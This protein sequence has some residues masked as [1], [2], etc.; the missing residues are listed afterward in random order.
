MKKKILFYKL[1][2]TKSNQTS[3][4]DDDVNTATDALKFFLDNNP[5]TRPYIDRHNK[6]IFNINTID[7]NHI[8][9]S[10]GRTEDVATNKFSRGR[11]RSSFNET[12]IEDLV[13]NYT[14][15]YFNSSTEK[16]AL[17]YNYKC[18]GFEKNFE[19]FL[20]TRIGLGESFIKISL[21]S[22]V[23]DEYTSFLST[24]RPI[25]EIKVAYTP[26]ND[27]KNEYL[28]LGETFSLS[29]DDIHTATVKL[30]L[31]TSADSQSISNDLLKNDDIAN[32]FDMFEITTE[33]ALVDAV[34]NTVTKKAT[35]YLTD[36]DYDD[37]DLIKEK[38]RQ[39]V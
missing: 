33:D 37:P 15:F 2:L 17:I 9:G 21:T 39:L 3:L 10:F 24:I 20:S 5:N 23:E 1:N 29:N 27:Y 26:E 7:E 6:V 4:L 28:T 30:K 34:T 8:F 31:K 11:E 12:T 35:I 22:V 16:V 14:Y 36:D 19:I 32:K 13:E 18:K 25:K 38:M